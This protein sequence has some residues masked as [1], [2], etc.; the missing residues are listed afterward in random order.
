MSNKL[1]R[2][3]ELFENYL[4]DIET[5]TILGNETTWS[6]DLQHVAS[7]LFPGKFKGIY[8]AD[9]IPQN[10]PHGSIMIVNT[11]TSK[12]NDGGSHW[13][14]LIHHKNKY[15]L[16]DS[17]NR[18]HIDIIDLGYLKKKIHD[19]DLQF[20]QQTPL[21]TNCGQQCLSAACIY[22]Y[23]CVDLFMLL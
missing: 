14:L 13:V 2:A 19:T 23:H 22:Y 16:Y 9:K 4:N 11:S 20:G 10:T 17:F 6:N 18:S 12:D 1:V 21:E 5:N 8:L 7:I 15:L 3:N